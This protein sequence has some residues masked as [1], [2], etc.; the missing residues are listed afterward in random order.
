M[1]SEIGA[2]RG[3]DPT[4]AKVD[5]GR[6]PELLTDAVKRAMADQ[7]KARQAGSTLAGAF[8]NASTAWP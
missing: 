4:R 6:V 5:G 8:A 3:I 1:R 7:R 2:V